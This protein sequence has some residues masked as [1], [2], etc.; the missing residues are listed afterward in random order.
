MTKDKSIDAFAKNLRGELIQPGY[1]H[2]EIARQLYNGMIDRC[3][4]LIARC[5]DV[6]SKT[7]RPL[8]HLCPSL[9]G[10]LGYRREK[11]TFSRANRIAEITS[12][13]VAGNDSINKGST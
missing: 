3:P 5:A 8:V 4:R 1:Q 7:K 11:A 12:A 6:D 13:P 9:V 2:Y 10:R